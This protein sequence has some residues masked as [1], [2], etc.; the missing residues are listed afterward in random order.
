M[1]SSNGY[2]RL[3]VGGKL[4]V[5]KR[6]TLCHVKG[7]QLAKICAEQQEDNL[8]RDE[9]NDIFLDLNPKYFSIILN[10]LR[11]KMI[12]QTIET[13]APFPKLKPEQV[14]PFTELVMQLGLEEAF[15]FAITTFK[16]HGKWITIENGSLATHTGYNQGTGFAL[17]DIHPSGM[18]RWQLLLESIQTQ[19]FLG[20]LKADTDPYDNR[21]Y[22]M[23]GSYGWL[24]KVGDEAIGFALSDGKRI[25][26]LIADVKNGD[27][28]EVF[29]NSVNAKLS[30]VVSPIREF[31]MF[32]P[33][34]KGWKLHINLFHQN[35]R[36]KIL[37]L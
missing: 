34:S 25:Y 21:S 17:S 14:R 22:D 35:D 32:L 18:I 8:H 3:N 24:V 36:I 16:Q 30:L 12:P 28:V 1:S 7:S 6:S 4:M 19:M 11:S 10:Y 5:A 29:L 26:N 2:I 9:N 31:H 23:E 20:V 33:N 27:T 37:P 15:S 13:N